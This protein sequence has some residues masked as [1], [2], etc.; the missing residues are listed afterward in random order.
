MSR[1]ELAGFLAAQP[2]HTACVGGTVGTVSVVGM[3][4]V[5][6]VGTTTV[7]LLVGASMP[8]SFLSRR[9][10]SVL[11][12]ACLR[13]MRASPMV[14]CRAT[15]MFW[16]LSSVGGHVHVGGGDEGV[17]V[18]GGGDEGVGVVGGGVLGTTAEKG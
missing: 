7:V 17:G 6:V 1:Q 12:T 16:E 18:M 2:R 15:V 9:S 14:S 5:G 13:R 10:S 4:V 3:L 8:G 11:S